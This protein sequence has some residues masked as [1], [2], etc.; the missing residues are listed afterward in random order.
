MDD[1]LGFNHKTADVHGYRPL[2]D[3]TKVTLTHTGTGKQYRIGGFA[4]IGA[5]D[6]WGFLHYSIN[7][8]AEQRVTIV[9]PFKDLFGQRKGSTIPRYV[10]LPEFREILV[11]M[12][13]QGIKEQE[14]ANPPK[15]YAEPERPYN[16]RSPLDG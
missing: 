8:P 5:T 7:D 2:Q 11:L 4:W 3:M 6:E 10:M 13:S 1:P 14:A 15:Q 9:R 16:D 12:F